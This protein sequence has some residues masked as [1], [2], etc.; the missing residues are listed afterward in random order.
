MSTSCRRAERL[1]AGRLRIPF[2]PAE[3]R[4]G[5]DR[6][7]TGLE[8]CRARLGEKTSFQPWWRSN[9]GRAA[10]RT[11]RL[12]LYSSDTRRDELG[13]RSTSGRA[14]RRR[15]CPRPRRQHVRDVREVAAEQLVA[16]LAGDR[17]L[18]VSDASP[19]TA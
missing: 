2:A 17:D 16:A 18:H 15:P 19:D 7:A 14:T 13:N 1:G 4:V 6:P 8:Q 3:Q 10:A 11:K 9:G 12:A 5:P